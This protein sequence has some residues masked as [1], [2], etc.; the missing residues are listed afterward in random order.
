MSEIRRVQCETASYTSL[1]G[2]V[3]TVLSVKDFKLLY[4]DDEGDRG[5]QRW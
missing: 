4:D 5:T 3:G 1:R 2:V